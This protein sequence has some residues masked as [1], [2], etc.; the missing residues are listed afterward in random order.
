LVGFLLLGVVTLVVSVAPVDACMCR[1]EKMPFSES[2]A[3]ADAVFEGQVVALRMLE[4]PRHEEGTFV[5][6]VLVSLRVLRSWKGVDGNLV[7]LLN[8]SGLGDCGYD[9]RL[10]GGYVV[11]AHRD[12]NGRLAASVC[13]R[14]IP[15]GD[16]SKTLRRLGPADKEFEEYRVGP[17]GVTPRAGA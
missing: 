16:A 4:E 12:K 14:T 5:L 1:E 11:F 17:E 10:G 3:S 8:G 7:N 13:G 15:L 2:V 6:K 9:F